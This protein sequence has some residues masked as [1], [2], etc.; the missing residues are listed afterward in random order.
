MKLTE[1]LT[2]A[3]QKATNDRSVRFLPQ[4]LYRIRLIKINL[5]FNDRTLPLSVNT[6]PRLLCVAEHYVF[7][8]QV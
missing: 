6:T 8:L 5:H 4:S 2:E 3:N 7:I 1:N